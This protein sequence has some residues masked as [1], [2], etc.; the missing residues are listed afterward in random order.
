MFAFVQL[1][2]ITMWAVLLGDE[3]RNILPVFHNFACNRVF[4]H[5]CMSNSL[6]KA[7]MSQK[8]LRVVRSSL[9]I[10]NIIEFSNQKLRRIFLSSLTSFCNSESDICHFD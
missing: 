8:Y 3:S 1:V 10:I 9:A 4:F 7:S 6:H 5:K 2:M